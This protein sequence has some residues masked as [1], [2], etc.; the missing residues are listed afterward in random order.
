[1]KSAFIPTYE[2]GWESAKHKSKSIISSALIPVSSQIM[3]ISPA[4]CFPKMF[5]YFENSFFIRSA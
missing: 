4:S 1:M 3:L 2:L 5:A